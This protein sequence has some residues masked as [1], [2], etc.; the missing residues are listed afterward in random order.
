[1][2]RRSGSFLR[3]SLRTANSDF[4][5]VLGPRYVIE[6]D[7]TDFAVEAPI[8]DVEHAL[9]VAAAMAW[10]DYFGALT[11]QRDPQ[12]AAAIEG[13]YDTYD[14]GV[15]VWIRPAGPQSGLAAFRVTPWRKWGW[16]HRT[17][18]GL[19]WA[20][21]ATNIDPDRVFADGFEQR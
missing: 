18:D 17:S 5:N 11:G 19:A 7:G 13:L 2:I 4:G 6:F 10:A 9:D 12:L 1:M 15:N 16:Q 20:V 8:H 21:A 3:A 14:L